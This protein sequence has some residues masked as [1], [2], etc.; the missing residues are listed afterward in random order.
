M[1]RINFFESCSEELKFFIELLGRKDE[2]NESLLN[3][4]FDCDKF[5]EFLTRHQVLNHMSIVMPE[6]RLRVSD[7]DYRTVLRLVEGAVY[8]Q[9][10]MTHTLVE[11]S[12]LLKANQVHNLAFKGPL[13]SYELYGVFGLK[14]SIDLDFLI[15]K[16]DLIKVEK[17][18]LE[19][20]YVPAG[21]NYSKM[22]KVVWR[23]F[24]AF[25]YHAGYINH[26]KQH[27]VEM[28][29][30]FFASESVFPNT[31][32]EQ[33]TSLRAFSIA[34]EQVNTLPKEELFI[35]LSVHGSIHLWGRFKWLLDVRGFL[36]KY[37][38]DIDW[39][40]ILQASNKVNMKR[41]VLLSVYL[42]N[43][44]F[45]TPIPSE[46]EG[47]KSDKNLLKLLRMSVDSINGPFKSGSRLRYIRV[48]MLV[49]GRLK[50]VLKGCFFLFF[51]YLS[52]PLFFTYKKLFSRA[53]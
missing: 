25:N 10:Q 3:T 35:Y 6:F 45:K 46:L 50:D 19:I 31:T 13:L 32:N 39:E 16:E 28:H 30:K 33:L 22:P 20:G 40:Y 41:A 36:L 15:K 14:S 34:G 37:E 49:R 12:K 53:E 21:L 24:S 1:N 7:D 11:V 4:P 47:Y 9:L 44:F 17:A 38:E 48:I 2:Q 23:L 43:A 51:Y 5:I 29:W 42:C 8:R 26:D 18:L 27:E 52:R